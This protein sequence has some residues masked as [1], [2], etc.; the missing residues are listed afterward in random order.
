MLWSKRISLPLSLILLFSPSLTPLSFLP[1]ASRSISLTLGRFS[2][3]RHELI[4]SFDSS[5]ASHLSPPFHPSPGRIDLSPLPFVFPHLGLKLPEQAHRVRCQRQA[6]TP[7]SDHTCM[8]GPDTELFIIHKA[9]SKSGADPAHAG[10][11]ERAQPVHVR[12]RTESSSA[13]FKP[14]PGARA[15]VSRCAIRAKTPSLARR[16]FLTRL[17]MKLHRLFCQL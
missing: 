15:R 8:R 14:H 1:L 6:E 16:A 12:R 2:S 4:P 11:G 7:S 5:T 17:L 9:I 3:I 13:D 10:A